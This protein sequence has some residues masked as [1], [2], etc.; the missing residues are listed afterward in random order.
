MR[1]TLKYRFNRPDQQPGPWQQ[2]LMAPQ[3]EAGSGEAGG[4]FESLIEP[5]AQLR[6]AVSGSG[7][8]ARLEYRIEAGDDRTEAKSLTLVPRPMVSEAVATLTP[9][10]YAKGLIESRETALHAQTG[11]IATASGIAATRVRLT[12]NLN[13]PIPVPESPDKLLPGFSELPIEMVEAKRTAPGSTTAAGKASTPAGSSSATAGS[14]AN[15]PAGGP[16]RA[17]R[18]VIAFPL[19]QTAASELSLVDAHGI[20]AN[21]QRPYR[22][23]AKQDKPPSVTLDKP[24]SDREVLT[25]AVVPIAGQGRDDVGMRWLRITG[26]RPEPESESDQTTS[27]RTL[28]EAGG[29]RVSMETAGQLD[30]AQHAVEPGDQVVVL[31]RGRDVYELEGKQHE[32]VE[33]TP[34][35]LTI[36][37]KPTLLGQ[38]REAMGALRQQSIKLDQRQGQLSEIEPQDAEPGQ[39]AVSRKLENQQDQLESIDKRLERNRVD[40]P[41]LEKQLEQADKLIEEARAASKQAGQK[42]NQS[43]QAKQQGEQEQAK[44]QK[45]QARE[46]QAQVRKKLGELTS[47]LDRGQDAMALKLKLDKLTRQQQELAGKTRELLPRTVGRSKAT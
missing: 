39:R 37:T 15:Q 47:L 40:E 31:A 4:R 19:T 11:R 20:E 21:S 41:G 27:T 9:P 36:I 44:Q 3:R 10:E 26:E 42:L 13:K 45:Q 30:L 43:K 8:D 17:D 18:F 28:S 7:A 6:A 34:R 16:E 14:A 12:L 1:V 22:F 2:T 32:P 46:D 33:S 23:E 29:Q 25:E 5:P 24:A 35:P 38:V